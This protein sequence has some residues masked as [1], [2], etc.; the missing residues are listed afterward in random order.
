[1]SVESVSDA[2]DSDIDFTKSH[3]G[4]LYKTMSEEEDIESY[5]MADENEEDYEKIKTDYEHRIHS[6]PFQAF[7]KELLPKSC[8]TDINQMVPEG[9]HIHLNTLTRLIPGKPQN[10]KFIHTW[11]DLSVV[12]TVEAVRTLQGFFP[13]QYFKH[14]KWSTQT[15]RSQVELNFSS[16]IRHICLQNGNSL[17]IFHYIGLGFPPPENGKI[18]IKD[19]GFSPDDWKSMQEIRQYIPTHIHFIFDCDKAASLQEALITKNSKYEKTYHTQNISAMFACGATDYL[20]IPETLPQDI[21]TCILLDPE[22]SI[23][24][25]MK[26][27][28][29]V[30][31]ATLK[32]LISIFTEAIARDS[33]DT[34]TFMTY[35]IEPPLLSALWK[36]FILSQRLMKQFGITVHSI[37]KIPDCSEH[38][39]WQQFEYALRCKPDCQLSTITDLHRSQFLTVEKTSK[40]IRAFISTLIKNDDLYETIIVDIAK[41]MKRSPAMCSKMAL[42]LESKY[43]AQHYITQERSINGSRA[44]NVVIS[45]ILL[46]E[47]GNTKPIANSLEATKVME[48]IKSPETDD[49]CKRYLISSVV[50]LGDG[51]THFIGL[52]GTDCNV[53]MY[54]PCILNID[55]SPETRLLYCTLVQAILARSQAKPTE[56]GKAGIHRLGQLLLQEESA[57]FRAVGVCI[58]A[59]LMYHNATGFNA[60]LLKLALPAV[61]D[62][63]YRVRLPLIAMI[64]RYIELGGTVG[65][66]GTADVSKI[67]N[68]EVDDAAEYLSD[69]VSFLIH[70]P[71]DD[72]RAKALDLQ[73]AT[74]NEESIGDEKLRE[75]VATLQQTVHCSLFSEGYEKKGK[76]IIRYTD[77]I[78]CGGNL[79][80]LETLPSFGG[81]AITALNFS[82]DHDGIICGS[83]GGNVVWG[84]NSWRPAP[85]AITDSVHIGGN[86][87]AV[88]SSPGIVTILKR[89][90]GKPVDCF[91]AGM[92]GDRG[93]RTQIFTSKTNPSDA[94]IS[95]GATE[96][97]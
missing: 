21:F 30:S 39:L 64:H 47:P 72:A 50:V 87:I 46:A 22:R 16:P 29:N 4:G 54:F 83:A 32:S 1:M 12:N 48:L 66:S 89:G 45:G 31:D 35:F 96:V 25:L 90:H 9:V 13:S 60:D 69:I 24:S 71:Y 84:E 73:T 23:R 63:S 2:S 7:D 92:E 37:P 15:S 44:W 51:Q 11:E 59:S 43:I 86:V 42:Y 80:L 40:T 76:T 57:L 77:D 6:N 74:K 79:E 26:I 41:F 97:V 49:I 53:H 68:G 19:N 17:R 75:E 55:T 67:L 62:G 56:S 38:H 28:D 10:R 61:L 33:L 82:L 8:Y 78:V 14:A 81:G 20:H 27:N 70:D 93:A 85:S 5:R 94:F 52:L 36:N 95:T 91:Q 34:S 3:G 58:L 88:C 65:G 18:C